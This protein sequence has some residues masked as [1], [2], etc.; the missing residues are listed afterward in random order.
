MSSP[1]ASKNTYAVLASPDEPSSPSDMEISPS[2]P[3]I[4]STPTSTPSPKPRQ[5]PKAAMMKTGGHR[6]KPQLA[7]CSSGSPER[8]LAKKVAV[9]AAAIANSKTDKKLAT[10]HAAM[11]SQACEIFGIP[12]SA[13]LKKFSKEN[14]LIS[15]NSDEV[16]VVNAAT[17]ILPIPPFNLQPIPKPIRH[18]LYL[19]AEQLIQ[20]ITHVGRSASP[21]TEINNPAVIMAIDDLVNDL[22]E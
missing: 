7:R 11:I 12:L 8:S 4:P 15:R 5:S 14:P 9:Q 21:I 1:V 3:Y 18:D 2:P 17:P 19:A 16:H 13:T 6:P 22:I 10:Q 20:Q